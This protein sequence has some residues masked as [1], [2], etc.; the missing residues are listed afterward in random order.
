MNP[1]FECTCPEPH[2]FA[3]DKNG[4]MNVLNK[5]SG[6]RSQTDIY[7]AMAD[8]TFPSTT[9]PA[10]LM[11][12]ALDTKTTAAKAKATAGQKKLKT[13]TKSKEGLDELRMASLELEA[14]VNLAATIATYDEGVSPHI[15]LTEPLIPPNA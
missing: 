6:E 8:H 9:D 7:R 11:R 4:Y 5:E 2:E 10:A 15:P 13:P 12:V 14:A 1:L 3:L